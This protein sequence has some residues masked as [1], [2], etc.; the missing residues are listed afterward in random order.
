MICSHLDIK[1]IERK[2]KK[3]TNRLKPR[4]YHM[5]QKTVFEQVPPQ[6]EKIFANHTSSRRYY[7]KYMRN[8]TRASK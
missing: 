2:R 6:G 5:A 4:S 7:P 8:N 3:M 1:S